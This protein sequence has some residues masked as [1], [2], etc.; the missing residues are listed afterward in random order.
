MAFSEDF[1]KGIH[2]TE[3]AADLFDDIFFDV[4]LVATRHSSVGRYTIRRSFFFTVAWENS[5][6][7]GSTKPE[8]ISIAHTNSILLCTQESARRLATRQRKA[9][10]L[11]L[12]RGLESPIRQ[13]GVGDPEAI[14]KIAQ[15]YAVL[16]DETSALRTL[17]TS[18]EAGFFS[19]SYI[20]SDPLLS[21]LHGAPEFA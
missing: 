16:G 2:A 3:A 6:K 11:D 4:Q 19:Y 9:E 21:D 8:E 10:G 13:R 1:I 14:Y 12:L 15:A 20:A 5:R 17:R 18:V 7:S